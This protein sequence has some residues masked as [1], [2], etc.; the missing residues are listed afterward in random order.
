MTDQM[1]LVRAATFTEFAAK[2]RAFAERQEARGPG[3][4]DHVVGPAVAAANV[5]TLVSAAY[6]NG[7]KDAAKALRAEYVAI[8]AANS[9]L[10]GV[11]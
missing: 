8:I 5:A 11:A 2:L 7:D 3:R 10:N 6:E 9:V 1:S 4:M